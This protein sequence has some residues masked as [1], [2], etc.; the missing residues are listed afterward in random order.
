M[1]HVRPTELLDALTKQVNGGIDADQS[2]VLRTLRFDVVRD[3]LKKLEG[4]SS[5]EKVAWAGTIPSAELG[6]VSVS[7][8]L[9]RGESVR[10]LV[11]TYD[12]S[13]NKVTD[14]S[15]RYGQDV[16][17]PDIGRT[18]FFLRAPS[19]TESTAI[20]EGDAAL[21]NVERR[22]SAFVLDLIS[23]L[24]PGETNCDLFLR[25]P[26]ASTVTTTYTTAGATTPNDNDEKQDSKTDDRTET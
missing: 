5:E 11:V 24:S 19:F 21:T 9:Y 22:R 26:T 13:E 25:Q 15:Y 12:A 3:E 2:S 8:V 17:G 14:L 6:R 10:S 20:P 23:S 4:Q 1:L 16:R 18:P 7:F